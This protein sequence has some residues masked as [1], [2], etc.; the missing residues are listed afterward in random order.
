MY[1]PRGFNKQLGD[2][3]VAIL[4]NELERLAPVNICAFFKKQLDDWKVAALDSRI[5]RIAPLN[6]RASF[7][8]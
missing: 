6:I 7:K 3:K 2:C 1:H 8:K 5:E 4:D